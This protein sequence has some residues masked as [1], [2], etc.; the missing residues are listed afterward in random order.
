MDIK[1]RWIVVV[2]GAGLSGCFSG[3]VDTDGLAGA[4]AGKADAATA[5]APDAVVQ[6]GPDASDAHD[7]QEMPS[8]SSAPDG[9]ASDASDPD[10]QD[11]STQDAQDAPPDTLPDTPS[12]TPADTTPVAWCDAHGA[13]ALFCDDFDGAIVWDDYVIS[14]KATLALSTAQ[15]SSPPRSLA[16]ATE[17]LT[18]AGTGEAYRE[19]TLG[20]TTAPI[21]WSYDALVKQVP[22]QGASILAQMVLRDGFDNRVRLSLLIEVPYV[23]TLEVET[24]LSGQP[25]TYTHYPLAVEPPLGAW[26]NV[27]YTVSPSPRKLSIRID[28]VPAIDGLPLSMLSGASVQGEVRV[29]GCYVAAPSEPWQFFYDNVL[30]R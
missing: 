18:A 2:I 6:D 5:D 29:G 13:G 22:P 1:L 4:D 23:V 14:P 20:T 27:S 10:A 11:A 12:D 24:R 21:T 30:L 15:F 16:F 17:A 25:A 8:D 28:D 9:D 3:L 7:V 26:S 19:K